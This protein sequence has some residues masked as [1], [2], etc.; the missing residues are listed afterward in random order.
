M[1]RQ[2]LTRQTPKGPYP[3]LPVSANSLDLTWTAANT[4]DKEQFAPSGDDL[5]L[6]RNTHATDPHTV[7]FTSVADEKNR[8]GDVSTYSLQAGEVIAFRFRKPGWKQSDGNI[9][10][11]ASNTAIQ[12]AVLQL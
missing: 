9:Y 4:T 10:M 7:T 3:T 1:P 11:E 6:V 2:T 12:Y 8:T 5:V